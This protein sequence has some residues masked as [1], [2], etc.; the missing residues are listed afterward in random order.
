QRQHVL[1]GR[2]PQDGERPDAVHVDVLVDQRSAS[3]RPQLIGL[4]R[5]GLLRA[6]MTITARN[7]FCAEASSGP[8]P[9]KKQSPLAEGA[10]GLGDERPERIVSPHAASV[11]GLQTA[12]AERRTV[13]GRLGSYGSFSGARRA[14]RAGA[15][16]CLA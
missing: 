12:R 13:R 5:N 4:Q 3:A 14:G 10:R 8:A 16:R 7:L 9:L 11:E 1:P 6:V 15:S 2:G